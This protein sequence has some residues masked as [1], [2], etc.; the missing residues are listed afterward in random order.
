MWISI[1]NTVRSKSSDSNSGRKKN[2]R[3]KRGEPFSIRETNYVANKNE[4]ITFREFHSSHN[5][6]NRFD[7]S[8]LHFTTD[9]DLGTALSCFRV[10]FLLK[11]IKRTL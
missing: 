4:E 10:Y 2:E 9:C 1:T 8:L 6:E 3:L 7:T 5:L 11:Y